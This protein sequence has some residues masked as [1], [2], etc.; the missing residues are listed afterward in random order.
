MTKTRRSVFLHFQCVRQLKK[1]SYDLNLT[2][3]NANMILGKKYNYVYDRHYQV[4]TPDYRLL[5]CEKQEGHSV[6][7]MF[8]IAH[9]YPSC[10]TQRR[11]KPKNGTNA[12]MQ[13][14]V[15]K[16]IRRKPER[17]VVTTLEHKHG[18]KSISI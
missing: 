11:K 18:E 12:K 17:I 6:V 7:N 5:T 8:V 4:I 3:V 15:D 16:T 9:V 1:K 14:E 2:A 10:I 13:K